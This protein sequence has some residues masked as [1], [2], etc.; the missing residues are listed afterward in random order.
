M[1]INE[2][3]ASRNGVK[4]RHESRIY[5]WRISVMKVV[6]NV[7]Y[8]ENII[9]ENLWK[10]MKALVAWEAWKYNLVKTERNSINDGSD[11]HSDASCLWRLKWWWSVWSLCSRG[12]IDDLGMCLLWW[13]L[14]CSRPLTVAKWQALCQMKRR[15]DEATFIAWHALLWLP[16]E[17]LCHA[18]ERAMP[19]F[20][21]PALCWSCSRA[22]GSWPQV[23]DGNRQRN[24]CV[25]RRKSSVREEKN[26]MSHPLKTDESSR[27]CLKSRREHVGS[28]SLSDMCCLFSFKSVCLPDPIP[29]QRS[30]SWSRH[31]SIVAILTKSFYEWHYFTITFH[32]SIWCIRLFIIVLGEWPV[33]ASDAFILSVSSS[34]SMA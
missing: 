7:K 5:Q 11:E 33:D 28:L 31:G 22:A 26:V 19:L 13:L 3:Y 14:F 18:E 23:T 15:R 4:K 27:G 10:T 9:Y 24:V 29:S 30:C 17:M 12:S 34:E 20:F 16:Q 21:S 25:S 2:S 32:C 6:F 1:F 8:G